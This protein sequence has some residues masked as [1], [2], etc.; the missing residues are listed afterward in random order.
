MNLAIPQTLRRYSLYAITVDD[1]VE[2][3]D[4]KKIRA[5]F[6]TMQTAWSNADAETFGSCFTEDSDFV[7]L[8]GDH[9]KGRESNIKVLSKLLN[10]PKKM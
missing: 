9:Y 5:V 8:R 2:S 4:E 7:N 10:G 1:Y 3:T 6:E